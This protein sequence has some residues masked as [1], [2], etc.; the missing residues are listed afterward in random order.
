M[1]KQAFTQYRVDFCPV[2]QAWCVDELV[3]DG[4]RV[5]RW[6]RWLT[7]HRTEE[8]AREALTRL[9]ATHAA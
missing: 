9:E 6:W 3:I 7:E 1:S 5:G 8:E 2:R 4:S